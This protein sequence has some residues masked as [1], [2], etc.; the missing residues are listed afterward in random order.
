MSGSVNKR[1]NTRGTRPLTGIGPWL[2][3][4]RRNIYEHRSATGIRLGRSFAPIG[5]RVVPEGP[6][7]SGALRTRRRGPRNGVHGKLEVSCAD[8]LPRC[9]GSAGGCFNS[10]A[11]SDAGLKKMSGRASMLPPSEQLTRSSTS[12]LVRS[13]SVMLL[14]ASESLENNESCNEVSVS[15][16]SSLERRSIS[17]R[18]LLSKF[19]G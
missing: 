4:L 15:V 16:D 3:S 12:V 2:L 1:A 6:W 11:W 17:N 8:V 18:K 5:A 13:G 10:R 14:S 7:P 9:N 19:N